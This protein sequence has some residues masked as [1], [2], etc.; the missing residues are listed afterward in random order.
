[1][2]CE[3]HYS[4]PP[5]SP[6]PPGTFKSIH[7]APHWTLA[8][9]ASDQ[10]RTTWGSRPTTPRPHSVERSSLNATP[11][12]LRVVGPQTH[13]RSA[14]VEPPGDQPGDPVPHTTPT[15][16][17]VIKPQARG[18]AARVVPSGGQSDGACRRGQSTAFVPS[19][20]LLQPLS[21][22]AEAPHA[23]QRRSAHSQALA[24]RQVV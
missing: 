21:T 8:T 2:C 11:I 13:R 4:I 1:M 5:R 10:N 18:H 15:H 9:T 20:D 16:L 12:C 22:S 7:D 14:R 6:V 23:I 17:R 24:T 3:E 19:R